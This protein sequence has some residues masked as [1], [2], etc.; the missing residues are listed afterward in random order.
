MISKFFQSHL[1]ETC[2]IIGNGKSL[3]HVPNMWLSKYPT[4]GTNRVYLKFIPDYF[5][6][7][8][9]LV[10]SQ[11]KSAIEMLDCDKFTRA[12]FIDSANPLNISPVREFSYRPHDYV[13][14]GYTITFVAMQL[15]YYFGFTTVLLIGVDHEYKYDGKPNQEMTMNGE[16]PNHFDPTYFKGQKW[17]NPDLEKSEISYNLAKVAFEK[18]GRRIVNLTAGSKLDVFPKG[19]I[20][21]W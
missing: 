5:C 6:C 8:N 16:D 15:A 3:R 19:N 21:D 10:L 14:E 4:F 12:G 1:N 13:Y 20:N 17:N 7:T 11:N 9:P 18:D 2:V